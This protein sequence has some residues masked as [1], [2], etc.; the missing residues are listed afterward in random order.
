VPAF[1]GLTYQSIGDAGTALGAATA[2][3][4]Q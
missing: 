1:A 3:H 4:P 2:G